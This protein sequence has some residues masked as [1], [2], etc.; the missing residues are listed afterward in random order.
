MR[1]TE[2]LIVVAVATLLLAACLAAYLYFRIF[3]KDIIAELK[4]DK[5]AYLTSATIYGYYSGE[6]RSV[7]LK[8]Q[9]TLQYLT[10][11]FRDAGNDMIG[12]SGYFIKLRLNNGVEANLEMIDPKNGKSLEILVEQ[13]FPSDGK[14]YVVKLVEPIPKELLDALFR[15]ENK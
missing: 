15:M 11:T 7:S 10:K 1:K 12:G 2:K 9:D 6:P 14:Y 3:P 4:N 8:E 13:P 5:S